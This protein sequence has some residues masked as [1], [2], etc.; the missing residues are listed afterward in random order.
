MIVCAGY[1]SLINPTKD[2]PPTSTLMIGDPPPTK[3]MK[4]NFLRTSERTT[5]FY[6]ISC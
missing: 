2:D 4:S 5:A 1:E 3:G 6:K